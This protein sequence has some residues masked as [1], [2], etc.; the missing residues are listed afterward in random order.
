MV[1]ELF[2]KKIAESLQTQNW[3]LYY[4]GFPYM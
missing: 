1:P 3:A 2:Y 4:F